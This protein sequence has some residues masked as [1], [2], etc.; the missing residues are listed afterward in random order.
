MKCSEEG[1]SAPAEYRYV[2]RWG[3][4]GACC[5]EHQ[6]QVRSRASQL[7]TE[8]ALV[9][10]PV[11]KDELSQAI[12]II[13]DLANQ[14]RARIAEG[15]SQNPATLRI[16]EDL[17]RRVRNCPAPMGEALA[18]VREVG[19]ALLADA[20]DT[21]DQA[22]HRERRALDQIRELERVVQ[23]CETSLANERGQ[24][25]KQIESLRTS[26]TQA[27]LQVNELQA[28]LDDP[29]PPP[30][31]T[32]RPGFAQVDPEVFHVEETKVE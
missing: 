15:T 17:A 11:P 10:V 9:A 7:Q 29:D 28:R 30:P 26:L 31:A 27:H 6:A 12:I 25:T 24:F 4:Q 19:N 20:L 2:W 32:D 8:I 5:A 13:R 16:G 3:E 23:Q 18:S 14:L 21:A 1:C 22:L